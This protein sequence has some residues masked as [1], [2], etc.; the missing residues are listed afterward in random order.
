MRSWRCKFTKFSEL[1]KHVSMAIFR[2]SKN[3]FNN[4]LVKYAEPKNCTLVRG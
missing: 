1:N 2:V 4:E 3:Y